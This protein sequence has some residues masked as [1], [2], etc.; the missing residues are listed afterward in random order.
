MPESYPMGPY[1]TRRGFPAADTRAATGYDGPM[2]FEKPRPRPPK[3]RPAHETLAAHERLALA[4]AAEYVGSPDHTDIPKF[5]LQAHPRKGSMTIEEAESMRLKNPTCILC[6]RKWARRQADATALLRTSIQRGNFVPSEVG[7]LP[8]KVWAIDPDDS[9]L[10]YE[11]K[12]R[13]PPNGYKAY[14]LTSFQVRF[15]LPITLR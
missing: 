12:L 3:A 5:Q 7:G 10:V 13:S 8:S 2:P 14:P 1:P 6:P 9:G 15:N 4:V 11:A